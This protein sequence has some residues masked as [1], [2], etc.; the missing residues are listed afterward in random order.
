MQGPITNTTATAVLTF[1][2]VLRHFLTK[3]FCHLQL[4]QLDQAS[5]ETANHTLN[6]QTI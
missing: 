6:T 3:V 5:Y 2:I 4:Q 1:H